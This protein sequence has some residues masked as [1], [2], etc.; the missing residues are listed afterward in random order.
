MKGDFDKMIVF[1][2]FFRIIFKA[3]TL[4]KHYFFMYFFDFM[5]VVK[6]IFFILV[7]FISKKVY[8]GVT[9]ATKSSFQKKKKV[10][11]GVRIVKKCWNFL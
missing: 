5:A 1:F 11:S 10:K 9:A 4:C 8:L 2:V 6:G 7:F 3:K